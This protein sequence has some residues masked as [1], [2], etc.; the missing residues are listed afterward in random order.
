MDYRSFLEWLHKLKRANLKNKELLK[1]IEQTNQFL[2]TANKE[3]AKIHIL[4]SL[5]EMIKIDAQLTKINYPDQTTAG[6]ILENLNKPSK[7]KEFTSSYNQ[8]E[9]KVFDLL[10][11]SE[12][13][14]PHL[15]EDIMKKEEEYFAKGDI[16]LVLKGN[17]NSFDHDPV[18][19]LT[20]QKHQA[21]SSFIDI[22]KNPFTNSEEKISE[23]KKSFRAHKETLQ[24][25]R[26]NAGMTFLK[27]VATVLT[28]GLA[29][30]SNLWKTKGDEL[31]E[32]M[33]KTISP[34]PGK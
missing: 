32:N 6:I 15:T 31:T 27:G 34:L 8:N 9:K 23:F 21:V 30:L 24:E 28:L 2:N 5:K 20:I 25:R 11:L 1:Q 33:E 14:L 4:S 22:L 3:Q 18:F 12:E 17:A 10:V 7:G 19:K 16:D 13:Y 26:D 29:M